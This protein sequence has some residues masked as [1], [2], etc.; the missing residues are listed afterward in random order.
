MTTQTRIQAEGWHLEFP[1]NGC[2]LYPGCLSCPLPRCR[3]DLPHGQKALDDEARIKERLRAWASHKGSVRAFAE[4][5]N[6]HRATIYRM[7]RQRGIK[8]PK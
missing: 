6:V 1:D 5:H 4:K 3:Y 7:L 8:I 2:S